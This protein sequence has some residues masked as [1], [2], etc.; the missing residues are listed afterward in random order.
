MSWSN[1]YSYRRARTHKGALS[2]MDLPQ[3]NYT[4]S[5]LMVRYLSEHRG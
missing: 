5:G 1:A 3:P 4:I 2:W